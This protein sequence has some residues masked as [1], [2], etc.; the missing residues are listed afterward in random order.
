MDTDLLEEEPRNERKG[1]KVIE[2]NHRDTE[3]T[4]GGS[5]KLEVFSL[6]RLE[7]RLRGLLH[8]I[9][10]IGRILQALKVDLSLETR[11]RGRRRVMGEN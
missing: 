11:L 10:K 8:R 4:E 5:L 9:N 6:K 3:G 7:P 2:V 1:A